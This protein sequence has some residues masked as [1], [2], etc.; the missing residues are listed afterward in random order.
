MLNLSCAFTACKPQ[1]SLGLGPANHDVNPVNS[2]FCS[3]FLKQTRGKLK[4]LTNPERTSCILL[5]VRVGCG[6]RIPVN[7]AVQVG[8]CRRCL[9]ILVELVLDVLSALFFVASP[10]FCLASYRNLLESSPWSWLP[11]SLSVW[12]L[13]KKISCG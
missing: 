6:R 3:N 1:G 12:Q 11:L 10:A 9:F 4:S 8:I 2:V 7:V 13:N 5:S